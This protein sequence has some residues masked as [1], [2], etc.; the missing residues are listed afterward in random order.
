LIFVMFLPTSGFV[1]AADDV[2][3]PVI[4]HEP[5]TTGT[6]G[7]RIVIEAI[8]TDDVTVAE[9]TLYYRKIGGLLYSAVRMVLCEGCINVYVAAIPASVVTTTGV[10]Y[11]ISAT[12]GNNV[13]THPAANPDSLPHAI[14]MIEVNPPPNAVVLSE[15]SDITENS[16][17]LE[18]STN[19]DEDFVR[20]EIYQST[21]SET[22]GT[23]IH[24]ITN[25]QITSFTVTGLLPDT[26]YFFTIKVV[27]IG[28][29]CAYSNQVQAKT[30]V[31]STFPW[32]WLTA[33]VLLVMAIAIASIMVRKKT[34][35]VSRK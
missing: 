30:T 1:F 21:S 26:A 22:H 7:Q 18:W 8:I 17:K 13:A 33:P 31:P 3:P 32:T 12:D 15:P 14:E 4:V 28:N 23:L 20:Y 19:P 2:T 6:D 35:R 34:K 25:K 11:Y 10:E 29:S 27:D 5:V 16:M 9:A 24:S